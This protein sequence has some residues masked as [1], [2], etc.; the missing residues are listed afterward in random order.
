MNTSTY[1]RFS[2]TVSTCRKSVLDFRL[3]TGVPLRGSQIAFIRADDR[4]SD[5]QPKMIFGLWA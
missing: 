3:A 5:D 4:R 2:R 1:I